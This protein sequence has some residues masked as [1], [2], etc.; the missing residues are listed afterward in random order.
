[1]WNTDIYLFVYDIYMYTSCVCGCRPCIYD[2]IPI[3]IYTSIFLFFHH[4]TALLDVSRFITHQSSSLI[5][6]DTCTH[7]YIYLY[8]TCTG[9]ILFCWHQLGEDLRPRFIS[10]IRKR[11]VVRAHLRVWQV[12]AASIYDL[13]DREVCGF[14][15]IVTPRDPPRG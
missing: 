1:M 15:T 12:S 13:A 8:I 3:A 10:D 2:I 11:S 7:P 6:H 5:H 4:S 14:S 9:S